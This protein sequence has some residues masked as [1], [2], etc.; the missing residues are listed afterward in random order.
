MSSCP[1]RSP[2]TRALAACAVVWLAFVP[3]AP[4][5][6]RAVTLGFVEHWSGTTLAGWSGSDHYSNPGTGGVNGDGD[7][8]LLFSTPGPAPALTHNL[9]AQNPGAS[10][11]GNWEAA[12]IT[13]VRFSLDDIGNADPLEIHFAIGNGNDGNF[14][15]Y[16]TGFIPPHDAWTEFTVDLTSA[17]GFTQIINMTGGTFDAALQNVDRVLIRHDLAPYSQSPDPIVADVGLDELLLT[18]GI[19]GVAA[20]LPRGAH[21][22]E[23]APPYPNPAH[24]R[25]ALALTTFESEGVTLQVVDIAG[26]LVRHASLA[27]GNPGPRLWVWDGTTDT[28]ARAPAGSYRVRAFGPSGGMSRPLTLLP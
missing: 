12:G 13:Q 18:N 14:W 8:F 2:L 19:V 16:N 4:S 1:H 22:I 23:M 3:L 11:T 24:G 9:G 26:R 17:T 25:V 6:S 27:A 15:Q 10:Y 21:P 28:G 5:A 7:G 20:P